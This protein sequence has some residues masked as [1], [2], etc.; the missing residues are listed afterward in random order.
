[1]VPPDSPGF[2][3]ISQ[4]SSYYIFLTPS[5]TDTAELGAYFEDVLLQLRKAFA[6]KSASVFDTDI[7]GN[8]LLM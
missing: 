8:N 1:M 5:E 3:L 4:I 2:A 7:L 6:D